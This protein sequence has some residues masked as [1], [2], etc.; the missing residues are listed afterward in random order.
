VV[1]RLVIAIGL[2]IGV[3]MLRDAEK[4]I[5]A[6]STW[7]TPPPMGTAQDEEARI[8]VI[9]GEVWAGLRGEFAP[10]VLVFVS[11]A[12]CVRP[13]TNTRRLRMQASHTDHTHG[14]TAGDRPSEARV[15]ASPSDCI[16]CCLGKVACQDGALGRRPGIPPLSAPTGLPAWKQETRPGNRNLSSV[17]L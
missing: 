16:G 13:E 14:S 8:R 4:E 3:W 9:G 2:T 10:R 15:A 7:R 17:A 11:G 5:K 1:R 6:R 12:K